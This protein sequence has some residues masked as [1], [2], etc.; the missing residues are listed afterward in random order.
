MADVAG[1]VVASIKSQGQFLTTLALA[2]AGAVFALAIQIVFHNSKADG[3]PIKI[4][5]VWLLPA[6]IISGFVS[7]F[8]W[9]M[10]KSVMVAAIPVLYTIKWQAKST[11]AILAEQG[12][13]K[14]LWMS[15][16]QTLF[17]LSCL[18]LCFFA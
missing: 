6:S 9:Y 8:F 14:I 7:I 15:V 1:A 5:H 13:E 12:F 4:S 17:L 18:Q 11:T 16:L 3:E 10:A 2:S